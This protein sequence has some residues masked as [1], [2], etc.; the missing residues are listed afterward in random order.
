MQVREKRVRPQ[1]RVNLIGGCLFFFFCFVLSFES[2][3][4]LAIATAAQ[5]TLQEKGSASGLPANPA[6]ESAPPDAT[7]D[8]LHP[9]EPALF[10][11][12][13]NPKFTREL[14]RVE[15]RKGD[16]IDLYVIRPHGVEKPPAVLYLYSYPSE[17]DR[18][19]D[20]S[21]CQRITYGGFAA[22]GFVSALTGQRYHSRPM[23][24]WFVSEIVEAMSTTVGD[25]QM[26]LDYLAKRGDFDMN[27]IGM[28]GAGSGGSIAV[29]A[30]A[31]DTRIKAIDLLDPWGDWPDWMAK[32]SL[33]PEVERPRYV[34]AEFLKKAAPYDPVNSFD[35][36]GSRP[37][38]IQDVTADDITP[39]ECQKKIEAAAGKSAQIEHFDDASAL[40]TA[41]G[42]GR[43]FQWIK[44]ELK[45]KPAKQDAAD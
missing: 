31:A 36:L 33:I 21:Y 43:L 19:K 23:K 3:S 28:F 12:D 20:D 45:P 9:T 13:E 25:V 27:R 26:I 22:I 1:G 34:T 37:V 30:A 10:Q 8:P 14:L 16:P 35:K 39:A 32:S 40:F 5:E 4:I 29:L 24:E 42:G 15:W 44:D 7:S 38:R 6:K 41:S 17:T 11:K 18:F 2:M